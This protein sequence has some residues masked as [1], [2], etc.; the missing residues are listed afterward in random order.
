MDDLTQ[1]EVDKILHAADIVTLARTAVEG[2]LADASAALA[3]LKPTNPIALYLFSSVLKPEHYE[4]AG[5]KIGIMLGNSKPKRADWLPSKPNYSVGST[6]FGFFPDSRD[7][8]SLVRF[9]SGRLFRRKYLG[10]TACMDPVAL[11]ICVDCLLAV[12]SAC[13]RLVQLLAT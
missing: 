3:A 2:A 11:G 6:D 10:R 5:L 8:I 9:P 7:S 4:N 13:A 1:A 12:S